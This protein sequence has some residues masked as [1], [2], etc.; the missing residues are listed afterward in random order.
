MKLIF[1]G[2]VR[3]VTGANYLVEQDPSTS[4]GRPT[5]VLVDCGL[6]QGALF[7]EKKNWEPFAYDPKSITAV[8]VTHAHIDHIGRLPVLV[9]NGFTGMIYSTSPTRDAGEL[10]LRDS[11]HILTETAERLKIPPL[12]NDQD[13]TAVMKLWKGVEYHWPIAVG[14]L[15]MEFYNG[16]HIL[17]SSFI[18]IKNSAGK[19]I[20]FS[21][22]LGNSPAPLLPDKEPLPE[23][24]YCVLESTYG[25]RLHEAL[26]QRKE[27]L[28]DVVEDVAKR[29]GVLMIPAFAMERA[30]ELIVELH[31]LM[32][33]G[34]IPKLPIFVDS[35]LAIKLIDVYKKYRKYLTVD[36]RFNFP[37]LKM[38]L[39]TEESKAINDV[40][41]PKIIIAGSGMSH[42][43]R[44]LFHEQRYLPDPQSTILMIGY[45]AHGSLGRQILDGAQTVTIRGEKISVR[46]AVRSIAGYSAHADQAQLLNWIAPQRQVLQKVF[47]VQG[48]AK[49][50]ETLQQKVRD[51]LAIAV[52]V[53][54]MGK[55][56]QL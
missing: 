8:V 22:D 47:I 9:K 14:D 55:G 41:P 32:E 20:I 35:P 31:Q 45:Q 42:G 29:G 48:E 37:M 51:E 4:S 12:Y 23:T 7:A 10:L 13:V 11:D 6:H 54:E 30:Q 46:C 16:G 19:R 39:T 50:S 49:A 5:F 43:G 38:T 3:E 1:Y 15:T 21:G 52:E 40:R 36:M 24:D 18:S 26:Q 44:I 56:Y 33:Q 27:L 34:R 53:P 25:D 28:E 2:G 17:G